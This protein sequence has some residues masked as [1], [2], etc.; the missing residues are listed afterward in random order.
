MTAQ[1]LQ[2]YLEQPFLLAHASTEML[3]QW[4][5]AHPYC[6]VLRLLLLKKYQ[7]ENPT[8]FEKRLPLEATYALDRTV[9]YQFLHTSPRMNADLLEQLMQV[10]YVSDNPPAVH[11]EDLHLEKK[12]TPMTSSEADAIAHSTSA[13]SATPDSAEAT[14]DDTNMPFDHLDASN[15]ARNNRKKRF[16]LP[17]IPILEDKSVLD[18][19]ESNPPAPVSNIAE[20]TSGYILEDKMDS[21]IQNMDEAFKFLSET[22]A[23]L[24]GLSERATRSADTGSAETTDLD[25]LVEDSIADHN[26]LASETLAELLIQQGQTARAIKMYQQLSL[27]FPE[28]SILFAEK[29]THLQKR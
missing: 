15:N 4:S 3:E 12:T 27:Q 26:N 20:H 10:N 24:K 16:R 28:K 6:Q 13:P 19:F 1:T 21:N 8:V 25:R 29:I 9:L 18:M 7:L 14:H 2:Q 22:E 23:F 5:A 11:A 17:R